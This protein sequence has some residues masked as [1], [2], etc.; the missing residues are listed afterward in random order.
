[1]A[2]PLALVVTLVLVG[3]SPVAEAAPPADEWA[4]CDRIPA[5]YPTAP[6]G[7]VVVEPVD[8][9]VRR[10]TAAHPAGTTFWLAA[11]THTLGDDEYGQIIPKDGNAYLGAPGAVLDGRGVNRYAFTGYATDVVVRDLTVRHFVAP[12]DEGVVNHDSADGW[13]IEHNTVEDNKGAGLMAGAHQRVRGNCLRDNGQYGLNAHKDGDLTDLVLEGNEITGNNTDDWEH[14]S[15]GCGCTGGVKFWSVNRADVRGNWVHGNHG[16]G[17]WM[18]TNN[19]D[20]LVEHNLVEHNEAEALFYETSYNAVVRDNTFRGNTIV[21]G[22]AFAARGDDFPVGTVYVSESGGEPRVPARTDELEIT[23]NRFEDNWSGV[24]LWENADR[25]CNSPANT[26]TGT[27]TKLVADRSSCAQPG[28]ADE[29]LRSDCRWRTQHVHVHDNTF[30]VDPTT[31]G[32]D[33]GCAR[34][35]VLSN[36][37]TYPEWSPYKADAVQRSITFEQDNVWHHNT[38]VGPWTFTPFDTSGVLDHQAWQA[39]PYG[40]DS[41]SAFTLA[42]TT[43]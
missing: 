23:A 22:R 7:A 17:L 40:Q 2:K 35:A 18:D 24:T 36:W 33:T 38:Y 42:P 29:P 26:S 14:R 6:A 15:P 27:C 19:N 11:G 16:A 8:G 43:C 4:V 5:A 28:I 9:E 1:M 12:R 37:G 25:F 39:A 13:V 41:C 3:L 32:C 20:F 21:T 31:V 10:Q 34:M 30:T